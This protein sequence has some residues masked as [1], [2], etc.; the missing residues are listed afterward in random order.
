MITRATVIK[1]QGN[2]AYVRA[3]RKSACEGCDGCSDKGACHSEII[4]SES[5]KEYELEVVN[6]IGARPGD[7]V[8]MQTSGNKVLIFAFAIFVLPILIAIVSYFLSLCFGFSPTA[9]SVVAFV[10]SFVVAAF[11]SNKLISKFSINSICKIIKENSR[12]AV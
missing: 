4:F 12:G 2:M 3:V 9:I 11:S 8:E 10:F 7:V 1:I 5:S 6:K